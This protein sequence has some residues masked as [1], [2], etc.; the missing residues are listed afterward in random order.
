MSIVI[1]NLGSR[2]EIKDSVYGRIYKLTL[3]DGDVVIYKQF[4]DNNHTDR[5]SEVVILNDLK[6]CHLVGTI[7]DNIYTDTECGLLMPYYPYGLEQISR[8]SKSENVANVLR[9]LLL[10]ANELMR[11]GIIHRDLKP[12][13]IV[14]DDDSYIRVI[15]FGLS[16]YRLPK[17]RYSIVTIWYRAPE[18][19]LTKKYGCNS[20]LWSI[21]CIIAQLILGKPLFN[22]FDEKV[23]IDKIIHFSKMKK[24]F[25]TEIHQLYDKK[26]TIDDYAPTFPF[27]VDLKTI[28]QETK[29]CLGLFETID[30]LLEIDPQ[31]RGNARSYMKCQLMSNVNIPSKKIQTLI[32]VKGSELIEYQIELPEFSVSITKYK[33]TMIDEIDQKPIHVAYNNTNM[34][35]SL[36]KDEK[37][38]LID[39]KIIDNLML[40]TKQF[41]DCQLDVL[42]HSLYLLSKVIAILDQTEFI[43]IK[44]RIKQLIGHPSDV[45]FNEKEITIVSKICYDIVD[46]FL[47]DRY[48]DPYT[49]SMPELSLKNKTTIQQLIIDLLKSNVKQDRRCYHGANNFQSFNKY[50]VMYNIL[51]LTEPNIRY[52]PYNYVIC[53]LQK[54]KFGTGSQILKMMK[55]NSY[56]STLIDRLMKISGNHFSN[57]FTAREVLKS[58]TIN[59][60]KKYYRIYRK[61]YYKYRKSPKSPSAVKQSNE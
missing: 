32:D 19:L 8:K 29:D 7:L 56:I 28:Y 23:L 35:I 4:K 16:T 14:I 5:I 26:K 20:D 38:G 22:S 12:D 45:N 18:I 21:G 41:E 1:T 9:Q 39:K 57:L 30:R 42:V 52:Y 33:N 37:I 59:N 60:L 58:H 3:S 61:Q 6:H 47:N 36:I 44:N 43:K 17:M 25:K 50:N 46:H 11:K 34:N 55:I 10:F 48:G 2:S 31:K 51:Y 15:D 27:L 49:L 54:I 40:E 13:N 53:Q 24:R